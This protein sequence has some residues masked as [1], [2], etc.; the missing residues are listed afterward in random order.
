MNSPDT[1]TVCQPTSEDVAL[2]T[3]IVSSLCMEDYVHLNLQNC[4]SRQDYVNAIQLCASILAH[5]RGAG[6]DA[7]SLPFRW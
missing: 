3:F 1:Q 2:A 5:Q 7:P 6:D 4:D